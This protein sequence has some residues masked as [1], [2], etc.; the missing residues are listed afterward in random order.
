MSD[1][2]PGLPGYRVASDGW[3][4]GARRLDSQNFDARPQGCAI[5]LLVLHCIS[6]P[7]GCFGGADI[8]R[9]FCNQ[10]DCASHEFYAQ[11][12]GV[13]VSAHF[14]IARSGAL[15]Q[16]VSCLDRAWHAGSSQ[17]DGRAGCNDFSIGI[18]LEG[19]EFEPFTGEQYRTLVAL[20]RALSSAYPLRWTRGH[21]EIAPG[22]K[23][24]PGP[25][26]DWTR[27]VR[28]E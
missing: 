24:D 11:L 28:D 14:L 4:Q 25:L 7:P 17:W 27:V 1:G 9:L 26:F 6:L 20:Q 16:F 15:T 2:Q 22:R 3:V 19:S 21:S 18:E 23:S 10:L 13:R 12:R 5:E 8:E